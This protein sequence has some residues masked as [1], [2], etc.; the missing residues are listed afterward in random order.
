MRTND[1]QF[2]YLF[3]KIYELVELADFDI[4]DED[5]LEATKSVIDNLELDER[6]Y[7]KKKNV[8]DEDYSEC[9]D[10]LVDSM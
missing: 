3:E 10:K 8:T 1:T 6:F 5:L 9:V 7:H 4:D 2:N